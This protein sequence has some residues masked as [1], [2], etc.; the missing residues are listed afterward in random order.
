MTAHLAVR[1][2]TAAAML[3][4]DRTE[5]YRLHKRG[6]IEAVRYTEGGDLRFLVDS[7][8]AF[9]ERRREAE[10]LTKEELSHVRRFARSRTV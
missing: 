5:V 10:N 3:D 1:A 2:V 8:K 9:I 4:V 6:E 7:L